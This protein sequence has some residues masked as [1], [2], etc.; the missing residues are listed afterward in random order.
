MKYSVIGMNDY[1]KPWKC[2]FM[3]KMSNITKG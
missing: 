2:T 3:I 1:I